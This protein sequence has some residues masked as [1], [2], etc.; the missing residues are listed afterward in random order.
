VVPDWRVTGAGVGGELAAVGEG[1]SV[2]DL[3]EDAGA[4]PRPDQW[5]SGQ[6]LTKRV[7]GE[8][9]LDLGERRKGR[10]SHLL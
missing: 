6:Q 3:G 10:S 5:H 1:R 9:L 8:R 7:G 2:A 4:G